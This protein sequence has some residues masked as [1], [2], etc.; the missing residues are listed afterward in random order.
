MED[1]PR[2]RGVYDAPTVRPLRQGRIIP[3]RAGFT[4]RRRGGCGAGRDHPRSRG[5]YRGGYGREARGDGSSP[6]ARGLRRY[7]IVPRSAARIIP[8]RAGFT[9]APVLEC[10]PSKD[11]PRS[12]GVYVEVNGHSN[13]FG[14]SSPLARGLRDDLAHGSSPSGIIPARAGFTHQ[15]HAGR[16][17]D[18]DHPRSRGVYAIMVLSHQFVAGSSPLARGLRLR[19]GVARITLRII[20]ARAGFTPASLPK[21]HGSWDHPRSRGVYL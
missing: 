15:D 3:A 16:P 6:L 10:R 18:W 8:A 5:V 14:G 1:H 13:L 7:L 4:S 19:R 11:H 20:P 9:P 2:S 21:P 17:H 12:R